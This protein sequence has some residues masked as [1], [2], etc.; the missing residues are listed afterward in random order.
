ME[1]ITIMGLKELNQKIGKIES[2]L[3][4]ISKS[5]SLLA[6]VMDRQYPRVTLVRKEPETTWEEDEDEV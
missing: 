2:D 3:E 6:K 1:Y 4:N 5:L